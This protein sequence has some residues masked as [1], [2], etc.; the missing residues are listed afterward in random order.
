MLW[1]AQRSLVGFASTPHGL[2]RRDVRCLHGILRP[3]GRPRSNSQEEGCTW[4]LWQEL[5]ARRKGLLERPRG[6]QPSL[7]SPSS[8][9]AGSPSLPIVM[10]PRV[11]RRERFFRFFS[12]LVGLPGAVSVAWICGPVLIRSTALAVGPRRT[13]ADHECLGPAHRTASQ[14]SV[15][16]NGTTV[17]R[18]SVAVRGGS[19]CMRRVPD[20]VPW[21]PYL[22]VMRNHSGRGVRGARRSCGRSQ[23]ELLCRAEL[24]SRWSRS[25]YRSR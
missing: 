6:F 1:R 24:A 5:Q 21:R 16:G 10:W 9:R 14:V 22:R 20:H 17:K 2:P 11:T 12:C 15:C 19:D 4:R 25:D 13:G 7:E 18:R 23:Q 3:N 8:A